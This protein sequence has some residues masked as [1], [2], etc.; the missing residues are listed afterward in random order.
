MEYRLWRALALAALFSAGVASAGE[1]GQCQPDP[2]GQPGR[3]LAEIGRFGQLSWHPAVAT[4]VVRQPGT[5][6]RRAEITTV[7]GA[8]LVEK[9]VAH[10]AGQH[11]MSYRILRSPLPV[12]GYVSTLR[13]A[14]PVW[15]QQGSV[16]VAFPAH[17]GRG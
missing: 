4:T 8:V 3:S 14:S 1:L 5:H 17:G 11:S 16:V 6:R 2:I 10:A 7:D 15:W 9:L 12:S 13:A